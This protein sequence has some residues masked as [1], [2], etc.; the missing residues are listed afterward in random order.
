MGLLKRLHTYI[1]QKVK[2]SSLTEVLVATTLILLIFGIATATLNNIL[3]NITRVNNQ[4]IETE[5]NELQY[6]YLNGALQVP[7]YA[8]DDEWKIEVLKHTEN[9]HSFI[10]FEAT[11]ILSKKKRTKK[12]VAIENN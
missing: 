11:H 1:N 2:A 9:N 12:L 5:L 3:H 8:E 7:F 4:A 6:Q 10:I